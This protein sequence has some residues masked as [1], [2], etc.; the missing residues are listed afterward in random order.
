MPSKVLC[1]PYIWESPKIIASVPL[2]PTEYTL[3]VSDRYNHIA[4]VF[5]IC[6]ALGY[7][8]SWK[9]ESRTPILISIVV[10]L[11]ISARSI[12]ILTRIISKNSEGFRNQM[13]KVAG[14]FTPNV[15][16]IGKDNAGIESLPTEC[17]GT[18]NKAYECKTKTTQPSAKNPFM[19]VLVDEMKY[20]PTRPAAASVLDPTIRLSL[21]EFFKT[22]F[23]SDPTDVFGKTQGQRQWVTMASTSIPNDVESYQNWLY[24]I[25]GKTCKEGGGEACLPGTDGG[26]FPWLN[27]DTVIATE[28]S[29]IGAPLPPLRDIYK[30]ML[31]GEQAAAMKNNYPSP[32]SL[33]DNSAN[34]PQL[35]VAAEKAKRN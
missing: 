17:I 1:D 24:R 22:E 5:V 28:G 25:P 11:L 27:E 35:L 31:L 32:Y 9:M 33:N 21:D 34:S 6:L 26:V 10:A 4:L 8:V 2:F 14:N 19:N 3:C 16:V 30:K 18:N 23:H 20:N 29:D 7:A 12:L 13:E 15:G